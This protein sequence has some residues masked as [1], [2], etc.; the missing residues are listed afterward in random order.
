MLKNIF[1]TL[2]N[3]D[4][5]HITYHGDPVHRSLTTTFWRR[6]SF[7]TATV[8]SLPVIFS[9]LAHENY[10]GAALTVVQGLGGFIAADLIQRFFGNRNSGKF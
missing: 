1:N 2:I 6:A 5:R 4:I 9:N 3:R 7:K 8:I 10:L